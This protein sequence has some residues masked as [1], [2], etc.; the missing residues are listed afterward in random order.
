[1]TAF[2]R[3]AG[4]AMI[5]LVDTDI[6]ADGNEFLAVVLGMA[7]AALVVA[8]RRAHERRV[9]PLVGGEPLP[10]LGV[11]AGALQLAL[12]AAA[13]VTTGA[14]GRTVE[15]GVGLRQ[16]TGRELRKS[17]HRAK[18]QHEQQ[19]RARYAPFV[20]TSRVVHLVVL[21]A[22]AAILV[23]AFIYTDL[24]DYL[25]HLGRPGGGETPRILLAHGGPAAATS[26]RMMARSAEV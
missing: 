26:D 8:P 19:P 11:T 6:P 7:L 22:S 18:T 25:P 21:N 1:M 12:A 4:L 2:Q 10:D 14:V 23:S 3:V 13:D 17:K 20:N 5:E 15:L 16:R 24:R 9:Q